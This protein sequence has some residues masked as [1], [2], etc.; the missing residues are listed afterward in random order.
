LKRARGNS[1]GGNGYSNSRGAFPKGYNKNGPKPNGSYDDTGSASSGGPPNNVPQ[2][3]FHLM[4]PSYPYFA[5]YPGFRPQMVRPFM[6]GPMSMPPGGSIPAFVP[7]SVHNSCR[8]IQ[9]DHLNFLYS[10]GYRPPEGF[11]PVATS[12]PG[13]RPPFIPG[14]HMYP[15]GM[16][17]YP[18]EM[19]GYPM[20]M[21]PWMPEGMTMG[22]IPQHEESPRS[23]TAH[24][25]G[26]E[27]AE[28]IIEDTAIVN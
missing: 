6:P 11:S 16:I 18:A 15:Q 24:S 9:W 13:Q 19:M 7:V 26:V 1:H 5:P 20:V 21:Q 4:E 27:A 2:P 23:A 12:A 22:E 10:V 25:D 14:Q 8:R 3:M 17:P 28:E